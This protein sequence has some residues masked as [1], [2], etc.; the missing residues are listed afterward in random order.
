MLFGVINSI[1]EFSEL[2]IKVVNIGLVV[3]SMMQLEL[4]LGDDR[5]QGIICVL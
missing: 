3:L 4:L 5:L 1:R 2:G